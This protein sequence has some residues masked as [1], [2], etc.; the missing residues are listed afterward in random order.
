MGRLPFDW[1]TKA[2]TAHGLPAVETK[3]NR[4]GIRPSREGGREGQHSALKVC[5]RWLGRRTRPTRRGDIP[6]LHTVATQTEAEGTGS[7]RKPGVETR[8]PSGTP[9]CG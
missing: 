3:D 4:M 8:P 1:R 5:E 7:A 6:A 9:R 2:L